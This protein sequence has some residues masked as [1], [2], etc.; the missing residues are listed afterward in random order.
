MFV[1]FEYFCDFWR[2]VAFVYNIG[3]INICGNKMNRTDVERSVFFGGREGVFGFYGGF[4]IWF[5]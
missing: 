2:R 5:G 1:I 3:A 4:L